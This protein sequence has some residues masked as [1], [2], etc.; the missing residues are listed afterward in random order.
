MST[1]LGQR[2]TGFSSHTCTKKRCYH[3][4]VKLFGHFCELGF[5]ESCFREPGFCELDFC[6]CCLCAKCYDAWNVSKAFMCIIAF[7]MRGV[8]V[9]NAEKLSEYKQSLGIAEIPICGV[10][11]GYLL[12][13]ADG[14][15]FREIKTNIW[16][17]AAADT[18]KTGNIAY[19]GTGRHGDVIVL[20]PLFINIEG[21]WINASTGKKSSF[22]P[23]DTVQNKNDFTE[24]NDMNM[25][26][27]DTQEGVRVLLDRSWEQRCKDIVEICESF[28]W[29]R[30]LKDVYESVCKALTESLN[31][32][33]T[34][35][36]LLTTDAI[37]FVKCAYY[38]NEQYTY[39]FEERHPITTGRCQWM[40][41]AKK[42][43]VM[44][45][46]HPHFQDEIPSDA[47][48]GG[49][50]GAVSIPLQA[51]GSV[52]GMCSV[53]YR[54]KTV[55]AEEDL[56]YL[57]LLGRLIGSYMQRIQDTKKAE[58]LHVLDE[59]KNL[60]NEIHDRVSS[61]IGALSVN[62]AAAT[63]AFDQGDMESAKKD[64]VRLES[65]AGTTMRSLR[66]EMLSL[67]IPLD[68]TDGFIEGIKD[69]LSTYERNWE[70]KTELDVSTDADRLVVPLKVSM[71]L[72]RILNECLTNTLKHANASCVK[73]AIK[74][75]KRCLSMIFEDD[76][77]GFDVNAVNSDRF[78]LRI[79][80]ER[81][82]AAGGQLSIIS[83]E[84]GTT[85]C[86]DIV[87]RQRYC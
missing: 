28:K 65:V 34:H 12:R 40:L 27:K 42:P 11:K 51:N 1:F 22:D 54:V 43:I 80:K 87:K 6:E 14:R 17:D 25:Q 60:S 64:L 76:G 2:A 49:I 18:R 66:D 30:Q 78:G 20:R 48:T 36:H 59:R 35:M 21:E 62:A 31:G 70:I 73:V 79:M 84:D 69:C 82:A 15:V 74:D 45:Y 47:L 61:L 4:Q 23:L 55:W 52:L 83:C 5:C 41:N 77:C 24:G 63:A 8:Y 13:S 16:M 53:V 71:Q 38:S 57:L 37:E 81:A 75:D 46:E 68:E 10:E 26:N 29:S 50:M 39:D 3:E 32:C 7:A 56:D 86:V 85:I 9:L 44:D 72:T 67:R 19:L 33:Q 58:E